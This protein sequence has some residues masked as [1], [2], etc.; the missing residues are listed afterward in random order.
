MFDGR[1]CD[2]L[3]LNAKSAFMAA[4]EAYGALVA[5][6]VLS[7]AVAAPCMRRVNASELD[8]LDSVNGADEVIVAG[9]AGTA[10]SV[11]MI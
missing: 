7:S 11:Y 6:K 8:R 5:V 1:P 10:M 9:E 4:M 3:P 2:Q